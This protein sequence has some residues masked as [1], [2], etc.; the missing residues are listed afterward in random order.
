[1][2][3]DDRGGNSIA[4]GLCAIKGIEQDTKKVKSTEKATI[5]L[6]KMDCTLTRLWQSYTGLP[7]LE[8]H[9]PNDCRHHIIEEA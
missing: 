9:I 4:R 6:K 7:Q 5:G 1:M 2:E 3:S 8:G